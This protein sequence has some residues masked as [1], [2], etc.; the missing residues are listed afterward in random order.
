MLAALAAAVILI[1]APVKV[2]VTA[3]GHTPP[4]GKRLNY[5]VSATVGGKPVKA[6]LTEQIIDPIGG[7]HPVT[8]GTTKKVIKNWHF[9]GVFRDF[10]LW[11]SSARGVPVT[12]RFI[13]VVGKTKRIV[14][15]TITPKA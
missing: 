10:I 1:A 6:L 5:S 14:N 8:Y 4:V 11:P 7:V 9:S 3:T 2:T 15:Y 13:V 12:W